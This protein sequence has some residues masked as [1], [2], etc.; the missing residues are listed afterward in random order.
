VRPAYRAEIRPTPRQRLALLQHAGNARWAYNWGL[1]QH[2]AAYEQWVAEGKPKKW[3]GWLNA[4]SLHRD[5]NVLKKTA[6]EDGGIP[7][8][9]EASKAAPQEA[10]RDLDRAFKNFLTGRA[11]YPRFKS[12]SRGIGGFRLT[13]TIKADNRT[14][15][16]PVIGRV[17]FQPGERG[18]LPW[19][20]H[21]QVSVT[22]QAGRW[23][24]SVVGPEVEEATPEGPAVGLDLGVARLATL[25]DGTVIENPKALASSQ[26]K[27][28][29]LQQEVSRKKK[30]SVNRRKARAK[31]ARAH[32]RVRNVRRDALHKATTSIA[33]R[34]GRVIIEDLKVKNMTA[35]GGSRK[36]G[37]NRVVLDAA[38]GEFRRLLEYKGK[39]YGCSVEVVPPHYTSQRCS[40]C[41][42][43]EKGN[44]ASQAEFLCLSCGHEAN[45]DLN[46]A[47]NILEA[48][49][50][51]DSLNACGADVSRV[52]PRLGSQLAVKQEPGI[53][54]RG[55]LD[56]GISLAT[57]RSL[58][59]A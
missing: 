54:L 3:G 37:L 15:Q 19:G 22:E 9:Y 59:P 43:V 35:G 32:A 1:R 33:T 48:A 23:F 7:W 42:H 52:K 56:R 57:V 50:S 16:L 29:K 27:I 2:R 53:S 20:K 14:I 18:Y 46:A 36:R 25:S 45:A 12:R 51:S 21:A 39:L 11:R 34:F 8:M 55:D 4:I 40:A 31:L 10:L 26:R 47:I 17:K 41:G 38:F 30:G 5:L 58:V 49:S 6:S 28:K 24:V 44:R 13:G